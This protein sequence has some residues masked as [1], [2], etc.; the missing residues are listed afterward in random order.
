MKKMVSKGD[1]FMKNEIAFKSHEIGFEVAN[2]LL[3]EEYVVML[4]YEED[5]LI[6][7]FEYSPHSDRNNVIFMNR[8]EWEE[9]DEAAIAGIIE[10]VFDSIAYDIKNGRSIESILGDRLK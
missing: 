1:I 8:E 3:D 10:D 6:V 7:N 5:F 9:N 2:R 4:S